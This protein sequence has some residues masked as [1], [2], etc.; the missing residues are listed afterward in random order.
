MVLLAPP[1]N[2]VDKADGEHEHH[3]VTSELSKSLTGTPEIVQVPIELHIG[4]SLSNHTL[5]SSNSKSFFY[6]SPI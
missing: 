1:P 4:L 2:R 3:P 5:A 6:Q